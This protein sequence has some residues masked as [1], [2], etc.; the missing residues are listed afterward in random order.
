MTMF[1][2]QFVGLPTNWQKNNYYEGLR[3]TTWS[4]K[5]DITQYV[6]S[7]SLVNVLIA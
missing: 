6:Y 2:L 5:D 1:S 3:Y 7:L 4:D